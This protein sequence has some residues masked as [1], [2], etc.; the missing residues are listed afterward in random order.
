MQW[1]GPY[2]EKLAYPPISSLKLAHDEYS[3]HK[4]LKPKKCFV[5]ERTR[6]SETKEVTRRG[7]AKENVD[8]GYSQSVKAARALVR[9]P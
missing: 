7:V 9:D 4:S 2:R 3:L 6:Y 8:V 5:P 1:I